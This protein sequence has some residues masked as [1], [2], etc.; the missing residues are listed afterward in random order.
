MEAFGTR[1]HRAMAERG[2]LCVGI[3]PH[4]QL[5]AAWGLPDDVSGLER[6]SRTVVDA[7]ADRVAA[8]KPQSAFFER[9][10]SHGVAILEST[11]RQLKEAGALVIL[12]VKRGD[13]GSTMAAYASAYLEP[14][15]PLYVDAITVSPFLGVGS[16]APVFDTAHKH[17]GGAFVL[18][19]TSNPEGPQVQHARTVGGRTVAQEIIDEISQLNGGVEPLGSIGAVVGATIG[20]TGHDLSRMGGPFL[21]PGLGAQGGQPAD[22]AAVFGDRIDAVLPSYSREVLGSGP[23]PAGLR[24]ATERSLDACRAALG[25][26]R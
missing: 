22:L 18:A 4:P 10:G 11:I 7:I 23:S 25:E 14:S 26:H 24:D 8:V 2:P 17:G 5:L 9:F 15:S 3:D 6:F 1:L 13:I 12:D 21:V 19:L 20:D 16:L